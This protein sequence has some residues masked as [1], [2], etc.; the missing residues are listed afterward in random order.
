MKLRKLLWPLSLV[1]GAIMALRNLAFNTGWLPTEQFKTPV[2]SVG[3]LSTGGTGKTP[4]V[5]WLLAHLKE[6][7]LGFVSRGYGRNT[8][9]LRLISPQDAPTDIGDEP[10][11]V[12][13]KFS[14]VTSAVSER[15]ALGI[16]AVIEKSKPQVIVLDDAF[17]H[18]YIVPQLSILLTTYSSP[19]FNDLVLPAGNLREF[20]SGKKRAHIIIVTKCPDGM[21]DKRRQYFL[22]KIA[23][24]PEQNVFFSGLKYQAPRNHDN[25]E[26]PTDV[27]TI[28]LVTGIAN[29]RPM[30]K[31]LKKRFT[32]K[33]HLAYPDHHEF[34]KKDLENISQCEPPI[35]TTEKDWVRLKTG[36]KKL[37]LNEV[38][39]LPMQMEILFNE[40]EVLQQL[41]RENIASGQS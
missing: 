41:I 1:Y 29:T 37:E 13:H 11:Q 38:F 34:S 4:M 16:K 23:P 8:K 9:G 3:N 30:L 40:S 20:A 28:T 39:Y 15:R 26:L 31:H 33:E 18:R 12:F 7:R 35:I 32:I 27:T 25:E 2:I 24:G 36:L 14:M 19:F 22:K 10:Y 6:M 17:Q 5:E 21:S